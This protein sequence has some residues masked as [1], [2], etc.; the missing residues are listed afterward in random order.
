L[1]VSDY[2]SSFVPVDSRA[3][4][5]IS[6]GRESRSE[7][8]ARRLEPIG[9]NTTRGEQRASL[10]SRWSTNCVSRGGELGLLVSFR[11]SSHYSL[12]TAS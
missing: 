5:T 10:V 2:S 6:A 8:V 3:Q 7:P 12:P 9:R 1:T 11:L 4:I